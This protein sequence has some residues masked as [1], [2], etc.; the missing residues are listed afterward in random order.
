MR[1][2]NQLLAT[3]PSGSVASEPTIL[4]DDGISRSCHRNWAIRMPGC[5]P[6][7]SFEG[8][9]GQRQDRAT[10]EPADRL[11]AALGTAALGNGSVG[12]LPRWEV[13]PL[14]CDVMRGAK[15]TATREHRRQPSPSFPHGNVVPWGSIGRAP[16]SS[17]VL[18]KMTLIFHQIFFI[19]IFSY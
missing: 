13:R 5:L 9:W 16:E 3:W 7:G 18:K 17:I 12:K 14:S 19:I 6:C 8:R 4:L 1:F 10:V 2:H 15:S 11:S